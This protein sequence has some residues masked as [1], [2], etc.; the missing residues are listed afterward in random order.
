[1]CGIDGC[2]RSYGSASSLCAHKRA[3]H[4]GWKARPAARLRAS[5]APMQSHN[6]AAPQAQRGPA[7]GRA[8]ADGDLTYK[9]SGRRHQ[10]QL[11]LNAEAGTGEPA[12]EEGDAAEAAEEE[13]EEE[14]GA[15]AAPAPKAVKAEPGK[16]A[17]G[18][19]HPVR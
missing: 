10:E 15:G 5:A 14:W 11:R 6:S 19:L 13:A 2:P 7:A 12:A 17:R 4:P 8:A 18:A 9:P 1:M 16:G 3:H